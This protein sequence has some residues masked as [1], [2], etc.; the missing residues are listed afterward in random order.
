VG[1]ISRLS[2][3][4]VAKSLDKMQ[5]CGLSRRLEKYMSRALIL[6]L[7]GDSRHR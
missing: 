6:T 4:V 7:F 3:W 1:S 2:G 5:H